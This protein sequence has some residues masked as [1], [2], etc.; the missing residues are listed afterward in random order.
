MTSLRRRRLEDMQLRNLSPQTQL[1]YI[2]R[3]ARFGPCK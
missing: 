3:V 2:Q 1:T